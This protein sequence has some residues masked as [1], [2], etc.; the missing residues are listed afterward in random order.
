MKVRELKRMGLTPMINPNGDL[1]MVLPVVCIT[2]A[3]AA[4]VTPAQLDKVF[5]N[6][7]EQ[8]DAKVKKI[9][10]KIAKLAEQKADAA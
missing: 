6:G 10:A 4:A 8:A 3:G 7:I 1:Y 5:E 2:E 9:R